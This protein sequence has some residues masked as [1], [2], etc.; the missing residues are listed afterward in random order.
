[1]KW[2]NEV[3]PHGALDLKRCLTPKQ[4]FYERMADN[5]CLMNPS[6]LEGDEIIS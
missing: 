1:M 2:S 6:F 4:A 3:R 5:D